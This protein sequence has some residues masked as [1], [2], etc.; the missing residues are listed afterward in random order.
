MTRT[1]AHIALIAALSAPL[2]SVF[3]TAAIGAESPAHTTFLTTKSDRTGGHS[4][5]AQA[6]FDQLAQE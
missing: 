4:S 5:A 3:S 2:A 1:I 6:I